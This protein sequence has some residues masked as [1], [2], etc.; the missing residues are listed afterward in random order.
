MAI[1]ELCRRDVCKYVISQNIDGLH[2]KSGVPESKISELHGNT[3]LEI[4]GSCSK[5][6]LRD[7]RVR[8]SNKTKEHNTGRKC[9]RCTRN[10]NDSILNFGEY[11][12]EDLLEK[13]ENT[14]IRADVML[15]LGS[16]L[17]VGIPADILRDQVRNGG[18]L[19]IVNL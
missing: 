5:H 14:G 9:T 15:C 3:N 10:L 8:T 12:D 6:H 7:F 2:L 1:A 17:R 19:I 13:A 4:C 18:K 16:S 11:Y